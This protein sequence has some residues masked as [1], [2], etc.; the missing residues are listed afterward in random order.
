LPQTDSDYSNL[1]QFLKGD[2]A[3]EKWFMEVFTKLDNSVQD[4][5]QGS[6]L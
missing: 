5:A 6:A 4:S 1:L 2:G 3:F